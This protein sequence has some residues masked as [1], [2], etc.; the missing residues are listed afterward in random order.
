MKDINIFNAL[1]TRTIS[2][3]P[4]YKNIIN[5]VNVTE[6]DSEIANA[7]LVLKVDNLKTDTLDIFIS[8]TKNYRSS[9]GN[10]FYLFIQTHGIINHI[11][12]ERTTGTNTIITIPKK[13][14]IPGI[15][16]FFCPFPGKL[17]LFNIQKQIPK[18]ILV[19]IYRSGREL[20]IL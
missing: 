16:L 13:E 19:L 10:L 11:S 20:K 1:S 18:E 4:D 9:N 5:K 3:K 15:N 6:I 7:G 14:L 12:T 8:D 2:T 17:H